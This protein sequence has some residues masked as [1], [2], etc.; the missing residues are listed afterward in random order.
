MN[1]A[2]P[3]QSPFRHQGFRHYLIAQ[4]CSS[5]SFQIVS[6]AVS[7]QLYAMTHSAFM[8]GMIGLMQFL[9]SVILALPAG[10]LADQYNRKTLIVT[11]QSIEL[12][13]VVGLIALPFLSWLSTSALLGLVALF[14][15]A[16]AVESPANT[17]LLPALLPAQLLSKAMATN[18]VF[19]EAMVIAGPMVGG[20]LYV[21]SPQ[22]AYGV[23]AF[24]YLVALIMIATVRYVPVAL[25]RLPMTMKNLFA[26]LHFIFERKDVL[27]VISLDLFAVLLGGVTALLPIFANDILHT[28]PWGLGALRA[29]PSVGALLT[30]IWIS[31]RVFTRHT[32]LIM[33]GCV[34]G[35]GVA[36]LVF[37]LSHNIILSLLALVALGG[38]DMVSMVIRGAMVQLDTPDGMRG[39]VNAVNS[40]FINTSNQFGEFE[41]G[42]LASLVGTVPAAVVGGVGTLV[43]VAVWMKLFPGLRRRQQLA[44][45]T[46]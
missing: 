22:A 9:P 21:Y 4:T 37:A 14:S 18:Q 36:T 15:I 44:T 7:W 43:V 31:R 11:G 20:L 16:K 23:A 41:T 3:Q 12:L 5:L 38:F 32:G 28:G 13:A 35:F 17:S 25:A 19:R 6:L 27:G 46:E 40:I 30:G 42:V 34:A 33:F 2:D 39:R 45:P 26:G 10:H 8:L 24:C 1:S 29:A